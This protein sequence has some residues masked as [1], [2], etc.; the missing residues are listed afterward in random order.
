MEK[1]KMSP[2]FFKKYI[3]ILTA[4]IACQSVEA[5]KRNYD[6]AFPSSEEKLSK[7]IDLNWPE[8]EDYL[9]PSDSSTNFSE[10]SVMLVETPS[11]QLTLVDVPKDCRDIILEYCDLS[12]FMGY[13]ASHPDF[14]EHTRPII[15]ALRSREAGKTDDGRVILAGYDS[16]RDKLIASCHRNSSV[17]P[18]NDDSWKNVDNFHQ[19]FSLL[20]KEVLYIARFQFYTLMN[21]D[22]GSQPCLLTSVLFGELSPLRHNN[23]MLDSKQIALYIQVLYSLTEKDLNYL[24]FVIAH[25]VIPR[26]TV[27]M[28]KSCDS[29]PFLKFGLEG[30][31]SILKGN[32]NSKSFSCNSY[33]SLRLFTSLTYFMLN[34]LMREHIASLRNLRN[35]G[36]LTES[37]SLLDQ[38]TEIPFSLSNVVTKNAQVFDKLYKEKNPEHIY[39]FLKMVL[40][41][42][43]CPFYSFDALEMLEPNLFRH[44]YHLPMAYE[45]DYAQ[46]AIFCIGFKKIAVG[47]EKRRIGLAQDMVLYDADVSELLEDLFDETFESVKK[48]ALENSNKINLLNIL[49]DKILKN[50]KKKSK[51][52]TK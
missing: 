2:H 9:F 28:F 15:E 18:K 10:G 5:T 49:S 12:G 29:L 35:H 40:A 43:G 38:V 24:N 27:D 11:E 14:Y 44:I 34:P 20:P 42:Y 17:D 45:T 1:N 31:L 32:I 36:I 4:A 21:G 8:I 46:R 22:S 16:Y 47:L 26:M 3:L 23:T 13:A 25:S 37:A 6:E 48:K 39:G 51:R 7:V 19:R 41:L 50:P 52:S 30:T 33:H